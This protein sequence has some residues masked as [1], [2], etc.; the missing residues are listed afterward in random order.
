LVVEVDV[1]VD[2]G[3]L[4]KEGESEAGRMTAT[5]LVGDEQPEERWSAMEDINGEGGAT[6]GMVVVKREEGKP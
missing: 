1:E 2:V 4:Q 3:G 6:L 5:Y